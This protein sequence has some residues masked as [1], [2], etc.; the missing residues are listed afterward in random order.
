MTKYYVLWKYGNKRIR[1]D[2]QF[3]TRELADK[4]LFDMGGTKQYTDASFIGS[5]EEI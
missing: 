3:S 1:D 5:V 4:Y 2:M